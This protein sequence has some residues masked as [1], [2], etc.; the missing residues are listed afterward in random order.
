MLNP[1]FPKHRPK[2][3]TLLF[4]MLQ[5]KSYL[6]KKLWKPNTTLGN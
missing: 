3:L 2:I 5:E 6:K 1:L 4:V